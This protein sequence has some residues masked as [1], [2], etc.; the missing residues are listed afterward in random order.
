M[1]VLISNN[2]EFNNGLKFEARGSAHPITHGPVYGSAGYLALRLDNQNL[3]DN[4]VYIR[5]STDGV[6]WTETTSGIT[7]PMTSIKRLRYINGRYFV[8]GSNASGI[9]IS[10]STDGTTWTNLTNTVSTNAYDINYVNGFYVI[11]A[12]ANNLTSD[13]YRS[14]NLT[15]WTYRSQTGGSSTDFAVQ[16]SAVTGTKIAVLSQGYTAATTRYTAFIQYSSDSGNTWANRNFQLPAG[17]TKKPRSIAT[18]GTIWAMVGTDGII[19]TT[20]DLSPTTPTWTLRS[21]GTTVNLYSISYENSTWVA[22]GN[23]GVN[24]SVILT[25]SD[26]VTWTSRTVPLLEEDNLLYRTN[27]VTA[28][29]TSKAVYANSKWIVGNY[30]STNLSTWNFLDY[31][32]PNRQPFIQYAYDPTWTTW[33]A[34]DFWFFIPSLPSAFTI[35]GIFSISPGTNPVA[36]TYSI[37]FR[38]DSTLLTSQA[39]IGSWNHLRIVDDQTNTAQYLNGN[40]IAFYASSNTW[41]SNSN[42]PLIIGSTS[43]LAE[44]QYSRSVDYFIDEFMMTDELLNSPSAT[45]ITVPTAPWQNN[46][47]TSI[48]LH[49]N[50]NFED[51]TSTP[52]RNASAAINS[53]FGQTTNAA[54]DIVNSSTISA[55]A[56]LSTTATKA[57]NTTASVSVTATL[58]AISSRTKQFSASLDVSASNLTANARSRGFGAILTANTSVDAVITKQLGE[59]TASLDSTSTLVT[60]SIKVKQF[61]ASLAS[62]GSTLIANVRTRTDSIALSVTSA[63][64]AS[65]VSI[66][67]ITASLTATANQ[68]V[69]I[70][71]IKQFNASLNVGAFELVTNQKTARTVVTMSA[72][73]TLS[74]SATRI[75]SG[76]ATISCQANIVASGSQSKIIRASLSSTSSLFVSTGNVK[77]AVANLNAG[78]FEVVT[79]RIINLDFTDTWIV[80][81]DNRGWIISDE[82]RL[83]TIPTEDR[84]YI[85]KG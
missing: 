44:S 57:V 79:G 4:N 9:Y 83:W 75:R 23:D 63:L 20:S 65:A 69:A 72:S 85:I 1:T 13:V 34:I 19:Y 56:S 41:R 29:N 30:T 77:R 84:T 43:L 5:K 15:S 2:G 51:D 80:P 46:D 64:A 17:G 37:G 27:G 76:S 60:S 62:S 22:Y 49:F 39:N 70:G 67:R 42:G 73:S 54:K 68:T 16:D 48:L 66:R 3:N 18:D 33:K 50:D 31:Q 52:I 74:A 61:G 28:N 7:M 6:T 71:R 59:I 81:F 47:Y 58:T 11:S 12:A 32:V 14:S 36:N 35:F 26:A 45:T 21:S 8:I 25:S 38:S 53:A 78:A 40:R 82:N 10:Y 55:T 24:T